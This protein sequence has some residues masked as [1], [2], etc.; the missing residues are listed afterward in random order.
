MNRILVIENEEELRNNLIDLLEVEGF[1]VLKA[2]DG[3]EG[4]QIA[5]SE[6]PDLILSD[7]MMPGL[8]GYDVLNALLNGSETATIP[9]IFL[10]SKA[11]MNEVR[12]GMNLGADDYITKPFASK[13]LL[14]AINLRLAKKAASAVRFSGEAE[15]IKPMS[16]V[17]KSQIELGVDLQLALVKSELEL[18]YQPKINLQSRQICG[19]EAL[20]RWHHPLRGMVS[21]AEFIPLAEESGLIIPIEEWVLRQ[22][23]HQLKEWNDKSGFSIPIAVNISS[24]HFNHPEFINMFVR[25]LKETGVDPHLLE[26]E[27]TE[28][29]LVK[30]PLTLALKLNQLKE[31]G[32]TLSIDDFGTGFSSISYLKQLPVDTLKLDR[33][34]VTNVHCDK[35]NAA[36]TSAVIQMAKNL[37]LKVV[38][39]GVELAEESEFLLAKGCD[40]MQGFLF[41]RPLPV[42]ALEKLLGHKLPPARPEQKGTPNLTLANS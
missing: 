16:A 41:S 33:S 22:V 5:R 26:M 20:L 15:L 17:R 18:Y 39:E 2:A 23:I 28:S 35:Q 21:P 31:L 32:I 4:I 38:A 3:T 37:N 19:L 34:Y 25:L 27:L 10:T 11:T 9:F 30:D 36:I 14:R 6:L 12:A 29:A 42:P 24:L 1:Q 7:I 13:E 8:N 40:E